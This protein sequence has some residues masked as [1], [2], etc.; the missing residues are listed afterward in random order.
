ME[1]LKYIGGYEIRINGTLCSVTRDDE[2]VF[3]GVINEGVDVEDVYHW[4]IKETKSK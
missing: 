1:V 3:S 2:L 4:I